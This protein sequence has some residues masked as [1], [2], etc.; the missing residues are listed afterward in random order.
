M[1]IYWVVS[2]LEQIWAFGVDKSIWR[3]LMI[4]GVMLSYILRILIVRGIAMDG[5]LYRTERLWWRAL[6]MQH[7]QACIY[8]QFADD[9]MC[10]YYDE[11]A[12]TLAEAQDIITHYAAA[13]LTSNYA[14]FALI[15][16]TTSAFVGTCGYHYLDRAQ[17]S[18]EIGYDIWK[19]YWRQGYARE[20]MPT[21]LDICF[22]MPEITLVYA[23]I[24]PENIASLNTAACVGLTQIAPPTRLADTPHVV[25]GITRD[26]YLLHHQPIR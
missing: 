12:C 22:A 10:R 6:S 26:T 7:D 5:W 25:M 15:S 23:V 21:L 16:A 18:V 17:G 8:R 3:P 13:T 11:A 14:R 19:D 9:D 1:P 24:L 2:M 4:H 20:M